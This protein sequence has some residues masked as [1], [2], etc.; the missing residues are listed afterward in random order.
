VSDSVSDVDDVCI[1]SEFLFLVAER[2][3]VGFDQFAEGYEA[4]EIAQLYEFLLVHLREEIPENRFERLQIGDEGPDALRVIFR[5]RVTL[6][7][8]GVSERIWACRRPRPR[9]PTP[10]LVSK[11]S[12]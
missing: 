7:P 12:G 4:G 1:Y 9:R 6:P 10:R 5:F 2:I 11:R 3:I 8:N